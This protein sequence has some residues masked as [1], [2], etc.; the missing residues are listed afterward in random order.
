MKIK[1]TFLITILSVSTYLLARPASK[2]STAEIQQKARLAIQ[3]QAIVPIAPPN[4]FHNRFSRAY[5]P[6]AMWLESQF[7]KISGA[8]ANHLHFAIVERHRPIPVDPSLTANKKKFGKL[9]G[10]P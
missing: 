4:S 6:P 9:I 1:I 2:H 8:P 7:T 10:T 5:V 3:K